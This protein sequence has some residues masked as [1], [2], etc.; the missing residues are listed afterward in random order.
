MSKII[1]LN[2]IWREYDLLKL[3][4]REENEYIHNL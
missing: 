3:K 1:N 4:V 2:K